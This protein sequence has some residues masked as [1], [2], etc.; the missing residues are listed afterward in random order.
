MPSSLSIASSSIAGVWI[1]DG[2]KRSADTDAESFKVEG[3]LVIAEGGKE[4]VVET[5]LEG[6]VEGKVVGEEVIF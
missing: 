1:A 4:A 2:I 3:G 5:L 6:I